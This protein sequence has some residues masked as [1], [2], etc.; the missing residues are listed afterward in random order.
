M[1]PLLAWRNVWRNPL[2]SMVV[3]LAIAIGIWADLFIT[4]FATGMVRSYIDSSIAHLVSH[5]QL[6]HPDFPKERDV[7]F[8]IAETALVE[9]VLADN[10]SVRAF[11]T[12]TLAN[13]MISSAKGARGVQIRGVNPE[14]EDA[15]SHFREGIVE[16][17]YFSGGNGNQ[18]L[19]G[20]AMAEKLQVKLRSKVVLTF[21]DLDGNITT[22]AFRVAGIFS[23]GNT[24]FEEANVYLKRASLW[25]LLGGVAHQAQ[26]APVHEIAVLCEEAEPAF[27]LQ[28]VLQHRFAGLLVQN[29]REV[30]PDLQL[31]E[32]QMKSISLI[33]LVIILLAL[34]FGIINTMLMAVLERF[35]E[36]GVLMAIGMN[37]L[38]VF[39]MIVLETLLLSLLGA[40]IGL[41][42]GTWTVQYFARHGL[43][44]EAF[45]RSMNE[46]G[47]DSQVYFALQGKT[48]W[49]VPL[50]LLIT[51]LLAAIYPAWRAIRMRPVAAIRRV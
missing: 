30:A 47:L 40:P 16:G 44:L 29:Y 21:Q 23:F 31:Y 18:I 41:L 14:Q 39:W 5:I 46:Y 37:K 22:G 27:A 20:R 11:S 12:R 2:R 3:I 49:E 35:R 38:R 34:I 10:N 51:A 13:G 7:R 15:V 4:G 33:Y 36:L 43:N 26:P 8:S 32:S 45:A 6:H 9:E 42:A 17:A 25:E 24:P 50:L 48:Y 1:V 19:I 28:K